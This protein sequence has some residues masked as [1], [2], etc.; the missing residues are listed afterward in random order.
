MEPGAFE[1]FE[2]PACK[3]PAEVQTEPYRRQPYVRA[4]LPGEV[5][6][7]KV[8]PW[9]PTHVLLVWCVHPAAAPCQAWVPAGWVERIDRSESSWR[10]PDDLH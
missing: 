3:S 7:A 1:V 9:L 2:G 6:D 4:Q 10:D 8:V 5:V